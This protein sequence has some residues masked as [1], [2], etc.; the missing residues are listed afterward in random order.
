MDSL[1]EGAI[2]PCFDE[3]FATLH[4]RSVSRKLFTKALDSPLDCTV[5]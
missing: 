3:E 1:V 5:E 2:D 4:L